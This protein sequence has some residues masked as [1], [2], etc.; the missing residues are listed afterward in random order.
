MSAAPGKFL[1]SYQVRD[2]TNVE[3]Y[4]RNWDLHVT[5]SAH[6]VKVYSINKSK[7]P[8]AARLK[9]LEEHGT[10][11]LPITH[12]MEFDLESDE[13]YDAAMTSRAWRDPIE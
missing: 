7:A 6:R 11:L 3:Y 9:Q 4:C 12:P 10:P 1:L 13:Q 2:D 5:S 8:T